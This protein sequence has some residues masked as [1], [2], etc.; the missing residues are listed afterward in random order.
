MKRIRKDILT[1]SNTQLVFKKTC[2]LTLLV[3]RSLF[4]MHNGQPSTIVMIL[5]L[6]PIQKINNP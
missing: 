2:E 4:E 1:K 3:K 6:S 5:N